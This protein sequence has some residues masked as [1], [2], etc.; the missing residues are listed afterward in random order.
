MMEEWRAV[1]VDSLVLSLVQGH[2]VKPEQ[3]ET[4]EDTGGVY[5]DVGCYAGL[6]QEI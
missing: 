5:F 4:D 1:V 6:Y 3:F 2:E